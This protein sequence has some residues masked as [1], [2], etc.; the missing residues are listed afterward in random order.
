VLDSPSQAIEAHASGITVDV[1]RTPST[2]NGLFEDSSPS[3]SSFKKREK[4]K[5]IL[6]RDKVL[7]Y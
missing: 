1:L 3:R 7:V 6:R 2:K 4:K 5:E